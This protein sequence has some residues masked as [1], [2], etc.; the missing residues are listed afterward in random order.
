[1]SL[2][3]PI[4]LGQYPAFLKE[5]LGD[6][7]PDFTPEELRV[8]KGSSDFYGMNTYT[9]NLCSK[10]FYPRLCSTWLLTAYHSEA[11]GNDEFQAKVEY[12]FTRPDGSQLGTLG[13]G[14][15]EAEVKRRALGVLLANE[16]RPEV[17]TFYLGGLTKRYLG[18]Q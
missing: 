8:V 4:Y 18:P 1:M 12:T 17:Q 13:G 7:L 16:G 10:K 6:R 15:V 14:C 9:T 3:D 11:G 2:Q 5:M